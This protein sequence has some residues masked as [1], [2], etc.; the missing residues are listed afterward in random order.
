MALNDPDLNKVH[1]L[2]CGKF[3]KPENIPDSDFGN[4]VDRPVRF[5]PNEEAALECWHSK[6]REFDHQWEKVILYD[7]GRESV[8]GVR[9][10]ELCGGCWILVL[11]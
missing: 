8:A 6:D 1:V 10:L 3:A 5:F 7:N 9:G 2:M 11:G 4:P